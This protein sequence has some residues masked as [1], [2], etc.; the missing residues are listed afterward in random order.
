MSLLDIPLSLKVLIN[1]N[2][3][4]LL[5]SHPIKVVWDVSITVLY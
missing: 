3:Q 2:L 5:W 1:S 4:T